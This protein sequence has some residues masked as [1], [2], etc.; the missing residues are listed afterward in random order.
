MSRSSWVAES[1]GAA[2]DNDRV[3]RCACT[4][5]PRRHSGRAFERDRSAGW[6]DRP[7]GL[8]TEWTADVS[9]VRGGIVF[10]R[11]WD[12][13]AP[14]RCPGSVR[15]LSSLVFFSRS[16]HRRPRSQPST[17]HRCRRWQTR[18]SPFEWCSVLAQIDSPT[19][20]TPPGPMGDL[21]RL[22]PNRRTRRSRR[23]RR[24]TSKN[25]RHR[26]AHRRRGTRIDPGPTQR[27]T[28]RV[29]RRSPDHRRVSGGRS[30]RGRRYRPTR[31]SPPGSAHPVRRA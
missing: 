9:D 20:N 16:G 31:P 3:H 11:S 30:G 25:R 24:T 29:P 15:R 14:T 13:A 5:L 12:R 18:L 2:T 27:P 1:S 28:C 7:P 8:R 4:G 22:G 10:P 6:S 21:D 26:T 17:S 23:R 19:R